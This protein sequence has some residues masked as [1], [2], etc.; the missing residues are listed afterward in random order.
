MGISG[1]PN[2]LCFSSNRLNTQPIVVE[3]TINVK[4]LVALN[5]D[6]LV[7]SILILAVIDF[8]GSFNFDLYY[9]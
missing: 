2:R 5:I 4:K 8:F 9:Y 3:A 7:S 6:L 1:D